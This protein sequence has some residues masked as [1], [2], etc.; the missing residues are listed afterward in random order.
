MKKVLL[1]WLFVILGLNISAQDKTERKLFTLDGNNIGGYIGVNPKFTTINSLGAGLIDIRAAIV[2]NKNWAVGFNTTGLLNDR[3]YSKIV[4]DGLYHLMASYQG[5]YLE[6]IFE[7][8]NDAK[9]S[10]S[11]LIGQGTIKYN[12]CRSVIAD[13]KW[14]EEIIDQTDF[15]IIEPSFD[16]YY[17]VYGNLWLGLN[18]GYNLTTSIRMM[19][20][21]EGILNKANGGLSIKYGLF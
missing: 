9:Y 14:Y 10:F 5:L 4:K 20:T 19:D 3:H 13:K 2:V 8:N 17:N 18:A 12:Y 6:R 21:D 16:I 7:I 15:Y 1:L 11:F